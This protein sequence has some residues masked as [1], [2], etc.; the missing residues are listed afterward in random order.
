MNH[1]EAVRQQL[2]KMGLSDYAFT[3]WHKDKRWNE[4]HGFLCAMDSVAI[5]EQNYEAEKV[6]YEACLEV[7]AIIWR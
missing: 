6:F 4:I 7:I 2:Y 3:T 1:F 5:H